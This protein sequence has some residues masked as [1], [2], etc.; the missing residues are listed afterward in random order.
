MK[1]TLLSLVV[2]LVALAASAQNEVGQ[3]SIAPTVGMNIAGMTSDYDKLGSKVGLVAGANVEIGVAENMGVTAGVFYS[4]Q[5]AKWDSE[6]NRKWNFNYLNVP[7]L[8]NYYVVKGLAVKAGIQAGFL[9]SATEKEDGEEDFDL[10]KEN[11][12]FYAKGFDLSIP[13]GVSYEYQNFVLDARYNIGVTKMWKGSLSS[14]TE[15]NTHNSV[16]Q[17]TLGYKF[18]L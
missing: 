13:V 14:E 1:K 12:E 10:K 2:A 6:D 16:I 8:F 3:V 15:K 11:E 7:V 9:L 4:Q 5:G 18:K 17:F